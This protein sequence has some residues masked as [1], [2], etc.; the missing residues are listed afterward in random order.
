MP[1]DVAVDNFGVVVGQVVVQEPRAIG[2]D[3][4]VVTGEAR[5]LRGVEGCVTVQGETAYGIE[6]IGQG[7][8]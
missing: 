5:D 3:A 2:D 8:I 4:S 6:V 1:M 7:W